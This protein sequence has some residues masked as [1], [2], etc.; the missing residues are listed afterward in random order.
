VTDRA[1]HGQVT[2]ESRDSLLIALRRDFHRY[3]EPGWAEFRT[4]AKAAETLR[5]AGFDVAAGREV[6]VPDRVGLP[7]AEVLDAELRRAVEQGADPAVV[8]DF[9]GGYTGVVGTLRGRSG[10]PTVALRF[11]MD[12]NAGV[13]A[14][15]PDHRPA[16]EGFASVNAGVVH[17][18][19][20]DAHTAIG[21]MVARRLGELASHVHGEIRLIFQ[22]AE[23]GLRGGRAMAAAGVVDGVDFFLGCHVGVQAR[24]T[25]EVIA[26]YRRI[27]ASHKFD[28]V[29]VGRNAHAAISPHEGRNALMAA[30]VAAQN[31]A[32]IT[33]HGEG[34][35]RI[36]VGTLKAGES[37]NTIPAHATLS[38]EVRA[39]S[40]PVLEFMVRRATAVVEAAAAMYE[41]DLSTETVGGARAADSDETLAAVVR[42]VAAEQPAVTSVRD[43]ADFAASD[44]VSEF[45]AKVQEGGGRAVY[46]GV[47]SEM[48]DLH[49]TPT[50][51]IDEE[52]LA[53]GVDLFLGCL[54]KLGAV[55]DA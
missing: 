13:E 25:G 40:S 45:M 33:R 50:F 34:D 55:D 16:R 30:A 20:H 35:S 8:R 22:P 17:N 31:L 43:A 15:D 2:A 54:R 5:D 19:G 12:A 1:G 51:D 42:D 41:V 4:A 24:A 3:A 9:A 53:T 11:E 52:A 46:F 27:L 37:R 36:N 10:G 21:L 14:S 29:F 44:D 47:G 49:H 32:A 39:D 38:A 26:G 48:A 7:P 23:E 28:A 18:C 6:L